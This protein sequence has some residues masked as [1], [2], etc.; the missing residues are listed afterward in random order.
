MLAAYRRLAAPLLSR[1]FEPRTTIESHSTM[2]SSQAQW[3]THAARLTTD[4]GV[5][6]SLHHPNHT[7]MGHRKRQAETKAKAKAIDQLRSVEQSWGIE[8][9]FLNQARSNTAMLT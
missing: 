5:L 1:G 4:E 8:A 3:T 6:P 2:A 7:V 9:M